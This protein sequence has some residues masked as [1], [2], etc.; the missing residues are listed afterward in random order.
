MLASMETSSMLS[1]LNDECKSDNYIEP[2]YKEWYRVAIDALIEHGLEAYQEFLAKERVSDFLAE[3][4][5]NY[6][7]KNVQKVAQSTAHSTDNSYDD[8]SSSGTYWPIESDV[9]APNLDLGWPY[10]MPGLLGGTHIDLLFHP[11]RAQLLTIKETIRKMIKEAR[12]VIALVMDIFTDVDIF[13]EIVEASTRGISIYILLDESNFNHFLNMTEKQGCQVQRLRNIRV[14]TV[15]GQDYLSKTGAKF[16]GKLEQKFLLIDCQKVMYGSYS[17]MWSFEKAHLSMVQIITGQLVESFDEEFRTLYAR[18]CVPNSFAQEESARVKH[19]KTLW[20]NG[21]YQRSLSSLASVSSQ[22]NLFGRQDKIH[23]LESSYFKNRGI[24]TLNEH[25]KYSIRNHGY[26]P[27]FIPNFN[28]P[29]TVRQYQSSQINENW[30]RHSYAGEQPETAPYL[31][32]NRVLNRNINPPGNWKKPSDSLSVASSSRGGYASHRN[33]P[34]Q[35]FADRLAQRKTT[36][37]AERNSNVRRSFNGTDNHIR[38]LQQRM[39]TLEHTTKSFLRNWRIESYLNDHSEAVP[40]SNG[41]A[42]GDRFEGYD[43]S[44]NLKA[45]AHYTHSRLRSSFVFKPTLPEQE[46]VNSCTTG[47]SNSTVIGS[48][49]SDTPKEVPDTPTSV[50]HTTDKPVPESAPKLPLQSEAPKMHTLQVPE[51]HSAVLNQTTNGHTD[52]NNY[53]YTSLCVNK[54]TENLKNQQN[55]NLLKRRSFPFFDHSKA[56]LDHGHSKHYVYST[57]TRNRVRQPEKPKEDLLKSSKS[58]HNVTQSIEEDREVIKREPPS[59][60]TAKS[61]SIAALLDMNKDEPSKEL[62]SKKEV[63]GS[64]SFLKKGSQKLRSLLSLTPEKKENLSKNKAPA[65]YRM[66][67]SS[68]TLVSESEDNQKPKKSEPKMDSSPRRKRSSSSNSQG[69]IHKSKEDVT[70]SSPQG[71]NSPPD[72]S[73]KRMPSPGP[74]ENKFLERAGDASAPRFNTE[75]IQYRDSKEINTVLAPERKPASSPRPKPN[76]LLR[77]HSTDRRIYS[78]FEP[79]YKIESSIQPASNVP[80]TGVHRPEIKSTTVGNSYGRS[81]PMLNYNTGVYHS[82]QPNENKFRGFMQK[83]GNFIHKNK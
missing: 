16:H 9:E 18:S 36:N 67:S 22:R 74:V 17:Y 21:T 57:L 10:V 55:E 41:S 72:E 13:K 44:E 23:K 59:G 43:S 4:E 30:K 2:H 40:D 33:T 51:N 68:D 3:E 54:Q 50:Q 1:S 53:L 25:D 34:A 37:L 38:F 81:S 15:K 62:T 69:S 49:G 47:S 48:Q 79:F 27:H 56:N 39:P 78:R 8:T 77:S 71:M 66:C 19:G 80:N 65:F 83:F 11:P 5:I 52:S 45:N 64:P 26:K 6:I 60:P 12:K 20:E 32:L 29:N 24:Y 7:L 63:K 70:V 76:E 82:Y 42:L 46:E 35:S 28:G 73:S 61:I 75:Q 31:L 14:R 58:M